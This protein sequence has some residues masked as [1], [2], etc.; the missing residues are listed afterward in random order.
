M[1]RL[2]FF[3]SRIMKTTITS[4]F[5]ANQSIVFI[6]LE[7]FPCQGFFFSRYFNSSSFKGNF[8]N[9][10]YREKFIKFNFHLV[11]LVLLALLLFELSHNRAN[12]FSQHNY[13]E[14]DSMSWLARCKCTESRSPLDHYSTTAANKVQWKFRMWTKIKLQLFSS[15]SSMTGK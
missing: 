13:V 4:Y 10:N 7:Y 5:I 14:I 15:C 12:L 1:F 8:S 9:F 3:W 6:F 11:L 2:T